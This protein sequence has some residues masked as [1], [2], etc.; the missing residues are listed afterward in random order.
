M[1]PVIPDDLQADFM[2]QLWSRY[3]QKGSGPLLSSRDMERWT[4]IVGSTRRKA[5][6]VMARHLAVGFHEGRL[7][8]WFCDAVV[9]DVIS[10]V[11]D[12][13]T[14]LGEE[15]WP[16]L[17][18]QV[19]LAFDAGEVGSPGVDPIEVHTRPMI[20]KIVDHLANTSG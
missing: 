20:A 1:S 6:D 3:E 5:Y 13:F 17:F 19:Y 15:S 9:I 8:F 18:N 7:P 10:F 12:E 11:Y 16:T 14:T 2:K 4:E